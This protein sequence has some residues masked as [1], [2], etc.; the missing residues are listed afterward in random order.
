MSCDARGVRPIL[1]GLPGCKSASSGMRVTSQPGVVFAAIPEAPAPAASAPQR[2]LQMR[3]LAKGFS[4]TKKE[5]DGNQTEMRLL[6]QPIYRYAASEENLL[7]G[8]RNNYLAAYVPVN[9]SAGLAHVDVSTGEFACL[10]ASAEAV[11][12]ELERLRPAELL[13]PQGATPPPGLTAT[14]TPLRPVHAESSVRDS[15]TCIAS[16]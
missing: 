3:Q 4:A 1:T 9:G 12:A 15:E 2:L 16:F 14:L 8:A 7:D 13:L 11:A 10:Q 5:R 6:P